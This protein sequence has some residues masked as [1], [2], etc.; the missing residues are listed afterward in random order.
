[1]AAD[2]PV[3]SLI[4]VRRIVSSAPAHYLLSQLRGTAPRILLEK[5]V[6]LSRTAKSITAQSSL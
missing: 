3:S 6:G 2:S 4:A 5:R 1:M